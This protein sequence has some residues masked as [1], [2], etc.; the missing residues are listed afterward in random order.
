GALRD[1]RKFPER[2]VATWSTHDTQPIG[3]WWSEFD[4]DEKGAWS[5]RGKFDLRAGTDA[6][7]VALA[8]I[9]L[10]AGSELALML[11]PEV[12]GE[13]VRINTPGTIGPHNWTYRLPQTIERLERDRRVMS[14]MDELRKANTDS[15]R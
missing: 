8:R 13:T 9:L 12:L 4:A 5:T 15:G 6:R 3:A 1:P 14:T 7:N 2:S 10:G 11:A